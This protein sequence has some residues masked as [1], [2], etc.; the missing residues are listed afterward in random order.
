MIATRRSFHIHAYFGLN[1][2]QGEM[3]LLAMLE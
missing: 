1:H 2:P 3:L